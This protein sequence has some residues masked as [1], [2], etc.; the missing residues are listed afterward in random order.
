MIING[1]EAL[2]R[3]QVKYLSLTTDSQW[4]FGPH[5]ELLVP[6]AIAA[7]NALCGVDVMVSRR[8]LTLLRRLQ[9]TPA[10]RIVRGYRTTY[11]TR[12]R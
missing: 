9:R 4:T 12:R 5:F 2:V 8:S 3:C 7:A 1:E 10:I 11:H 6:K